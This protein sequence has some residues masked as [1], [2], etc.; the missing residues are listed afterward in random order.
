MWHFG[1]E[2]IAVHHR[3]LKSPETRS[4]QPNM[5][6]LLPVMDM[7]KDPVPAVGGSPGLVNPE[8]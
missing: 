7:F 1:V 6:S 8:Y 4:S 3:R 2:L 5:N